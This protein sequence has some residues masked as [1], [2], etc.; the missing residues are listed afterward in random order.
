MRKNIYTITRSSHPFSKLL[1]PWF[2]QKRIKAALGGLISMTTLASGMILMPTNI[3]TVSA[4][5]DT[6]DPQVQIETQKRFADILPGNT[7]VSQ[8]YHD[9]HPGIDITAPLGTKIYPLKDGTVVKLENSKW[10]YG[11]AAYIDHGDG[12]LTLYAHMGK[13]YVEEGDVVTPKTVIG[14]VGI[15]GRTTGPHLHFELRV[16]GEAINPLPYLDVLKG[17]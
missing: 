11:R 2:E 4:S 16:K 14:E 15:T 17:K 10:N 5:F 9:G 12:K 13:V 3:G 7:G 1:R 8:L 6:I